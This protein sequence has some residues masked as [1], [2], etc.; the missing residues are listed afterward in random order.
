MTRLY[1]VKA[2]H[3]TAAFWVARDGTLTPAP[4]IRYIRNWSEEVA[5]EY[6]K[7]KGWEVVEVKRVA[8][9]G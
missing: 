6:F 9:D 2:P 8:S 5:L 1:Q 4:I 3:F 7:R